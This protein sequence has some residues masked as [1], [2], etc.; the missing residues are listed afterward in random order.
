MA[1]KLKEALSVQP[2]AVNPA[3]LAKAEARIVAL[4]KERD[5]LAV[6][7]EQEKAANGSAA[8]AAKAA[9]IE[10][11]IAALKARAEADEQKS[12]QEAARAKE[13]AAESEKKL[14]AATKELE[15]LKAA[16]AAE[17]DRHATYKARI[18]ADVQKSEE[19][20]TRLKE[21]ADASEKKFALV[22]KELELLKTARAAEADQNA[23]L[24][25]RAEADEKKAQEDMARLK[26]AAAE[27]G[28]LLAALSK[29]LELL[30]TPSAPGVPIVEGAKQIPEE[31]DQLKLQ[32]A[33]ISKDETEIVR[34]KAVAAEAEKKLAAANSELD[35]LKAARPAETQ[36]AEGAKAVIE[37]RD[38]LKEQLAERSKDLADAESHSSQELLHL[39]AALQQAEQRRDELE[40]KLAA[41]PPQ[42]PV[43]E[44]APATASAPPGNQ[45]SAQQ[46][47]RQIEQLQARIAVL[48]ANPVPYTA[49][50]LA[51]LKKAPAPAPTPAELPKAEVPARRH[52]YSSKDLPPGVGALWTDA[53]R[54]SM[55][56]DYD[57]A[58]KKF[59]EVLRQ[60]ETN[61]YVLVHLAN[62]QFAAGHLAECEKSLQRSMAVDHDDP[63]GLYMLGLL[64]YQ[65][66]R[67]DEALDAL[68]LSA[69]FDPT[70]SSTQNYLGCALAD[71]GLR[72]A[73]ETALRK[74]LQADPDYADA[75]FNL[76]V[77]YAGNKPPSLELARWHYKRALALGHAKSASMEKKLEDNPQP[78]P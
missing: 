64:R 28:K 69:K 3:E 67:L 56:H 53:V 45:P 43:K 27:S 34:L 61:V 41:A 20:M 63:A 77:V 1:G 42:Q 58:E 35:S 14:A 17:V 37:E 10:Q 76:A 60:D 39:R 66:D 47:T 12:R 48:E 18:E 36:T 46:V 21:A 31:P 62:A 70:N 15:S 24:K 49:E 22:N 7:L 33:E 8:S 40:K 2:A 78:P 9:A 29:E 74:A 44:T 57:T 19:D 11:E 23:A 52:V 16:H 38:K 73:A 50:E 6:A 25:A 13:A 65:Q 72:P 32:L 51:L 5:L 4:Q 26:E 68:S 71:K 75:H 59:N 30:K 55:D 54:A